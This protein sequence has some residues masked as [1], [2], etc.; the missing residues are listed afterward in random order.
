METCSGCR[1]IS[2]LVWQWVDQVR[3]IVVRDGQ[4]RGLPS[5]LSVCLL[6][7]VVGIQVLQGVRW[8][9]PVLHGPC[10]GAVN[11]SWTTCLVHG[12]EW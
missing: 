8:W 5:L 2:A 9:G 10:L 3:V 7:A 11:F 12:S 6:V 1:S 4:K